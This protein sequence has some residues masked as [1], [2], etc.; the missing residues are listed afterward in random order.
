MSK[1]E[2]NC[3]ETIVFKLDKQLATI[4]YVKSTD[5]QSY[6]HSKSEHPHLTKKVL[7]IARH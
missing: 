6:L 7:P 3:L 5:R 2:T 4:V 1:R